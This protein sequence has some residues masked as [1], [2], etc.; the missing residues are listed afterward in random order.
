MQK[1][2]VV[3]SLIVL[4]SSCGTRKIKTTPEV[5]FMAL[6]PRMIIKEY[7]EVS[8]DFKTLSGR[9]KIELQQADKTT[10]VPASFRMIKDK[11]IWISAFFGLAKALITPKEISFYTAT[12]KQFFKGS[13]EE[14]SSFIGTEITYNLLERFLLGETAVELKSQRSL[15]E[16][17]A[18]F[19]RYQIADKKE[20]YKLYIDIEPSTFQLMKTLISEGSGKGNVSIEYLDYQKINGIHIPEK[21]RIS[22]QSQ[23]VTSSVSIEYKNL[24]INRQLKFPY[25]IPQGYKQLHLQ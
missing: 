9:M 10:S 24:S 1:L 8:R 17:T 16:V 5:A 11:G 3:L 22:A 23:E 15:W 4:L 19:Y 25:K 12:T 6:S 7:K 21:L 13:F 14:L 2:T 20:Q 18:D